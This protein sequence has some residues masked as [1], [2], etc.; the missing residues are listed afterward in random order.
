MRPRTWAWAVMAGILMS[1]GVRAHAQPS[2]PQAIGTQTA[3]DCFEMFTKGRSAEIRCNFPTRMT[4][5]EREEVRG[6]TRGVL[7]DASCVVAIKIERELIDQ[8]LAAADLVFT[9]P[10]QPVNCD[11]VTTR[12]TLQ[13]SG[14]FA[15]R[16]TFKDGK[17]IDATPGLANVKGVTRVISLPVELWVNRGAT[18]R[19]GMVKVVNAYKVHYAP[20]VTP[21]SA[22]PN[23][24]TTAQK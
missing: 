11:L 20:R 3:E 8:A 19:E 16:I 22:T 24:A 23:T 9:A 6:I 2:A 17:A 12:G 14:T 10:P 7:T 1:G 13:I 21:A 18:V 4:E 5:K 15:P